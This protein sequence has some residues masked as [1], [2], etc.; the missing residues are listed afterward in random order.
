M[1]EDLI[2]ALDEV[3]RV[4]DSREEYE[5]GTLLWNMAADRASDSAWRLA[6]VVRAVL[7]LTYAS[8]D[9]TEHEHTHPSGGEPECPACWAEGIRATVTKAWE[10]DR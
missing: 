10:A 1:G 4:A 9:G 6:A 2:A 8:D 5:R 7:D 3:Q